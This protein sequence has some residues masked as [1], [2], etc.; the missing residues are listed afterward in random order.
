MNLLENLD[1]LSVGTAIAATFVL[2]FVVFFSNRKSATNKTFFVFAIIT[3][4]WGLLNYLSYQVSNIAVAF[5][6][7]RLEIFLAVWHTLFIF[8]LFYIFPREKKIG[9]AHV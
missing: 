9:R 2:G 5:W 7:L 8:N 6:F 1:L 4:L 3:G